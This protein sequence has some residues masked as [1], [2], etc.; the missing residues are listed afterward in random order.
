MQEQPTNF[1]VFS[2]ATLNEEG[3]RLIA[4]AYVKGQKEP[5]RIA[6]ILGVDSFDLNLIMHPLVRGFIN[7][8]QAAIRETYSL[9]EHVLKLK[10]IRDSA[11]DDDNFK[12]AL[13]AEVQIGKA[14][15]LYDP[16]TPDGDSGG[17]DVDP[18]TL[19]TDQ[20]RARLAGVQKA[21][22]A[23]PPMPA[24]DERPLHEQMDA[25]A[26]QDEGLA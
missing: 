23:P 25:E 1:T 9:H 16:K 12:V 26:D 11:M 19:T 4:E 18:A 17:K 6:R 2:V 7:E 22:A 10:E 15:G 5:L 8:F 14:A 20:L 3:A 13:S 21:I 24:E